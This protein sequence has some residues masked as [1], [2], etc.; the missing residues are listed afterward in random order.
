M[1][2]P[3]EDIEVLDVGQIY[4]GPYCGLILSYLGADVI[5]V[6]PPFGEPLRSRV[7]EGEPEELVM[8]NSNKKGITLNLKSERGKNIFKSLATDVDVI[9]ENFSLGTMEKLGLGYETLSS[10]N[11]ELIYAQGTGFGRTGP[12]KDRLAMDLIVQ[13]TSGV[14]DVTGNP[15]QDPMKTGIAPGDF[16]GGIHLV[17]GIL[18]ALY[19]REQT[20]SG[21]LVEVGM[22][23]AVVP[24]LLS[25]LAIQYR[26]PSIPSRTGNRHSA[27]AK[28]PYNSYKTKDGFITIICASDDHWQDLLKVIGREDLLG[29]KRF[30]TNVDRVDNIDKVDEL[31]KSWTEDLETDTVEERLLDRGIPCG[32]VQTIQEVLNDPHLQERNSIV[33]LNHPEA[34]EIKVPGSP[35]KFPESSDVAVE[36]SP[37]KG[38]HNEEVLHSRLGLSETEIEELR[39]DGVI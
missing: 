33:K 23:D 11:P 29:D 12:K 14:M 20:G 4:N 34:G 22:Y 30:E 15:D 16:F 35:I 6:E 37:T 3:L 10:I 21:Q 25:Q 24:S 27:M 17:S 28:A 18:A 9:I 38:E 19:A 13:A 2:Q 7:E 39:S 32:T 8:L 36:P 5:K 1:E 31:V 26:D